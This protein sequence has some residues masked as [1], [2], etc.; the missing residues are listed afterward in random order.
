MSLYERTSL[1]SLYDRIVEA[2]AGWYGP[3]HGAS[4]MRFYFLDQESANTFVRWAEKRKGTVEARAMRQHN[5]KVPPV[6]KRLFKDK[7]LSLV[8]TV[9]VEVK[10]DKLDA[11]AFS[12]EAKKLGGRAK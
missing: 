8:W 7:K 12:A 5:E 3:R 4:S 2:T 9:L 11:K 1:M 10:S 6:A